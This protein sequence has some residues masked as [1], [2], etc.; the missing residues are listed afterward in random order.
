M[1]IP[2]FAD[3]R[4]R[5]MSALPPDEAVLVFGAHEKVRNGDSDYRYRP[6][7]D[8]YWLTGWEDPEVAVFV[9]PGPEPVAMFVQP[10]DRER[11]VWAGRRPGPAR[12]RRKA[13]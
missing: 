6:D 2:D 5:L 8:V 9:K 13:S 11:E 12:S 7:S 3:H 1:P 10:R 4:R